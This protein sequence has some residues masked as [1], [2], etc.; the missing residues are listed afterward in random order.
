MT[1]T[2]SFVTEIS[3]A[4]RSLVRGPECGVQGPDPPGPW[5]PRLAPAHR[6]RNLNGFERDDRAVVVDDRVD[7]L[8]PLACEVALG[9]EQLEGRREADGHPLVLGFEAAF[10]AVTGLLGRLDALQVGLDLTC[11]VADA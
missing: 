6:R 10:R 7:F 1:V 3:I 5:T 4:Y 11:G 2:V 8:L 9:L